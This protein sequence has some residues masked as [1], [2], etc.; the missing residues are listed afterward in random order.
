MKKYQAPELEVLLLVAP[1]VMALV[2]ESDENS[3]YV[4]VF[5]EDN[6]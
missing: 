6:A 1:D 2:T 5:E 3:L 4:D